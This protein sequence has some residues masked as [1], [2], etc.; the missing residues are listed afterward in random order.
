MRSLII[1]SVLLSAVVTTA[2]AQDARQSF[3]EFRSG[4][5]SDYEAFRSRILEH[6]ADFLEG[7]WHPYEPLMEKK[8]YDRP[9]PAEAP[10]VVSVPVAPAAPEIPVP[11]LNV[12]AQRPAPKPAV[13]APVPAPAPVPQAQATEDFDF[14][15]M[16][17]SVPKIDFNILK[18]VRRQADTAAQWRVL[19][20]GQ[21]REAAGALGALSG[22]LGLN[23]Y[24]AFRLGEAYLKSKFPDADDAALFSALHYLMLNMGYDARL[25]LTERNIPLMLI[26]FVQKVYGSIYLNF[27]GRNYTAFA[28]EGATVHGGENIYTC[29]VPSGQDAGRLSDLRLDGLNLPYKAYRF[30]IAGGGIHISGETNENFFRMLYRY[31]QMPTEDFASSTLDS[32]VREDIAGQIRGQLSGKTDEEA[33]NAL[34]GFFHQGFSY[35]TDDNRHGFEKPYFLEETLYYDKCDCEDRAIMFTWLVWNVLHLPTHLNAYPG[36]ESA[37]VAV[38]AANPGPYSYTFEGKTFRNTDPTYIGS[39]IGDVMPQFSSTSPKIDKAY[40]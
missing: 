31:P 19:D 24:L 13:P 28:P 6:Y 32:K 2:A 40:K 17:L 29:T 11:V 5:H 10:T 3:Q 30:D 27:D 20:K 7:E 21:A 37:A 36:H 39:H 33:V 35:A 4:L 8:K 25:A 18:S 22:E 1:S 15:G 16:T 12:P 9:K 34:M 23:G 14:Y 38:E 26:P